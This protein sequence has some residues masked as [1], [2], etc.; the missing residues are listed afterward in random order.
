MCNLIIFE[1]TTSCCSIEMHNFFN[2]K[3]AHAMIESAMV[4]INIQGPEIKI[5]TVGTATPFQ[6]SELIKKLI[7]KKLGFQELG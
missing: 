2:K 4:L 1:V 5:Q 7:F 3:G 6:Y